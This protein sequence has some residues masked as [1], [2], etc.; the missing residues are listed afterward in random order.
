MS[1]GFPLDVSSKR[2]PI[3]HDGERAGLIGLTQYAPL[4]RLSELSTLRSVSA[5][6]VFK[7]ACALLNS[8]LSG[9][10]DVLFIN[11]EAGRQWPFMDETVAKH[12]PNP[13]SIAGSTLTVVLNR[14]H[15]GPKE[16]VGLFLKSLESEQ[17]LLTVYA[18]ALIESIL[19]QLNPSDAAAFKAAKRQLLNWGPHT[20]G[21]SAGG[22]G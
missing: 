1:A 8:H 19:A 10:P 18:H 6:V 5:P 11:T 15:I 17:R 20:L 16:K 13:I 12:L 4:E 9:Q 22:K 21:S 2:E 14:S 3:D 7:A